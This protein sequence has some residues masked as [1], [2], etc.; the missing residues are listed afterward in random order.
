LFAPRAPAA[1]VGGW[2]LRRRALDLIRVEVPTG[3]NVPW[4][5]AAGVVEMFA[6]FSPDGRLLAIGVSE[7][8]P[9]ADPARR[10]P[11]AW[12]RLAL[13]SVTTDVVTPPEG[14][15]DNFARRPVCSD[16]SGFLIFDAPFDE[17]TFGCAVNHSPCVDR[18]ARCRRGCPAPLHH[19]ARAVIRTDSPLRSATRGPTQI[20]RYRRAKQQ[21]PNRTICR[22]PRGHGPIDVPG[23]CP[24][25][26]AH[27]R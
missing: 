9:A 23:I 26:K 12:M 5:A 20:R 24:P 6:S 17:S 11:P 1:H 8:P 14:R 18:P 10:S 19:P 13:V 7:K 25:T 2:P 21:G 3:R 16:D 27:R 4:S 22:C 15:V